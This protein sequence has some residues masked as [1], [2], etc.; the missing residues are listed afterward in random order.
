MLLRLVVFL[1]ASL[2]FCVELMVGKVAMPRFGGS[3]AVW[4]TSLFFFQLALLGGYAWAQRLAAAP[5]EVQ[6]RRHLG[7]LG[8][9]AVSVCVQAV[10]WPAPL[11][12]PPAASG[13]SL[14]REMALLLLTSVGLPFLALSATA[15]LVQV[16][17]ARGGDTAPW[18]LYAL[19]NA[20][21]LAAL[22]AYPL[23]IEPRLGLRAQGWAWAG[24]FLVDAAALGWLAWQ[25]AASPPPPRDG[26]PVPGPGSWN[27]LAWMALAALG[28]VLLGATTNV[29][30]QDVSAGPLLWALPLGVYLVSFILPFEYPRWDRPA[31]ALVLFV[32]GIA[33]GVPMVEDTGFGLWPII[34]AHVAL[35]LG[36]SL[37]VHGELYRRRPVPEQ[38]GGYYLALSAGGA[39][40][41][42]AVSIGGPLLLDDHWEFLAAVGAVAVLGLLRLA[43]RPDELRSPRFAAQL[44]LALTLLLAALL[45]GGA[46]SARRQKSQAQL[47]NFFG[48]LRVV[49]QDKGAAGHRLELVHGNIIHGLQLKAPGREVEATTYYGRDS[50][51]GEAIAQLR[52]RAGR[53]LD[54]LVLGLGVGTSAVHFGEGDAVTFYEIDPNV[55]RLA[56]G[57]GGWFDFLARSKARTMLRE[58]DARAVL[59][60]DLAAGMAPKDLVVVDVFSGDALP[61]HLF[62]REA[63]ALY[64]RALKPDGVLALHL[65]NRHLDLDR[66]AFPLVGELQLPAV[67]VR[68]P[69]KDWGFTAWW[70]IASRDAVLL[71]KLSKR[72]ERDGWTLS[73]G[74]DLPRPWTD[75]HSSLV[76]VWR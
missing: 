8:L 50:G 47:R 53:P 19:S 60:R 16:W 72:A 14:V 75:D 1:G 30:C 20:G 12:P 56:R 57:T 37:F 17:A 51:L 63:L 58:G 61:V 43:R 49:E 32:L 69:A 36:G 11:V 45:L 41:S 22:L 21:A 29:L 66:V 27:V 62:T 26:V 71:E 42:L 48:V 4:T 70:M 31:V 28:T 25:K 38:L 67:M 46:W 59:E 7:L 34:A 52:G 35:Q 68:S 24:L 10:L 13:G 73:R 65:S 3:P 5:A 18:R 64:A 6:R 40:G 54:A 2:L 74:T 39:L 15:P 76:D 55:L 44:T 33:L 23:V 9:A